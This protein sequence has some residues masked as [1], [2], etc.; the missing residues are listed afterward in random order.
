MAFA[1]TQTGPNEIKFD[2]NA[3]YIIILLCSQPR[4]ILSVNSDR[5]HAYLA[6]SGGIEIIPE[7]S[8][9]YA[10]WSD[11]KE[12]ILFAVDGFRLKNL[13]GLEFNNDSFEIYSPKSGHIDPSAAHLARM[14]KSDLVNGEMRSGLYFDSA[15]TLLGL[16]ILKKYTSLG[17]KG[18]S[19]LRLIGGLTPNTWRLIDEYIRANLNASVTIEHLAN[20]SGFSPSHFMRAF[21]RETG[22][23][24]HRYIIE[25]RIDLAE[26]LLCSTDMTLAAVAYNSGF[27]S[28]S[29]MTS[30]MQRYKGT[31]PSA[32]RR[33]R[34][35]HA[36]S[37]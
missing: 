35:F 12:N 21:R 11:S 37:Y 2:A 16:H 25:R 15:C 4:R 33:E 3:H 10:E 30:M 13:A 1:Y 5:R 18:G 27:A 32:L 7:S 29:H 24:P 31:T 28:N 9:V 19:Q 20:L 8:D 14:L 34:R 22:M 36:V 6:P 26:K 17:E 23:T